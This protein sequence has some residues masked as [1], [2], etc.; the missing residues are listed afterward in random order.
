MNIIPLPTL[1]PPQNTN[2][3]FDTS[4]DPL[5]KL[6]II[7]DSEFEDIVCE[8]A[9]SYLSKSEK[10]VNVAQIGG[11]KDSG[12]DLIAY[13]D[14]NYQEFDI[15]QCKHYK[16]PLTPSAYMVEFG[17]LCYYTMTQQY[18]KPRKYF[19]VA[20]NGIGRDLRKLVESPSDINGALIKK[21]DKYCAPKEKITAEGVPLTPQLRSYIDNFDFSI[22]S[23]IAPATLLE[24]FS[25]TMWF[26]Y[27]FGGG[28]KKRKKFR[29]VPETLSPEEYR[30]EYVKQLLKVYSN[31]EGK[32]FGD[33]IS[34]QSVPGLYEHF[35]CQREYFYHAD[36]LERF[37]RDEFITNDAY[38]EVKDQVRCGISNTYK[39]VKDNELERVDRTIDRAQILPISTDEF[40]DITIQ[41]KSGI[42]HDLVNDNKIRWV[43][44]E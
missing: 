16:N 29:A 34:L 19:I 2:C 28:L 17:K 41:E 26:K 39:S 9:T 31:H 4:I 11:S 21:W 44:N 38:N 40:A 15:F 20:S 36:A 3:I 5:K 30:M 24:Q 35:K 37:S 10:Y 32:N 33:A 18:A 7:G 43:D 13:I 14:E 1:E 8:W 42:C 25:Q 27:H 6:K 12:R 23:D 22:V